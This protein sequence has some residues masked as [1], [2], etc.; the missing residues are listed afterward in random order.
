M[1]SA[2]AVEALSIATWGTIST[3]HEPT[4]IGAAATVAASSTI[5]IVSATTTTESSAGIKALP[6]LGEL[7][8]ESAVLELSSV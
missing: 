8:L 6:T 3:I 2:L 1:S 7:D 4:T 5:A